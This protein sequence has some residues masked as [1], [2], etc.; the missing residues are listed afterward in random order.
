MFQQLAAVGMQF[1]DRTDIKGGEASAMMQVRNML[2]SIAGGTL[3]VAPPQQPPPPAPAEAE[4]SK[5]D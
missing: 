5:G 1:L 4:P 3:V 2:A